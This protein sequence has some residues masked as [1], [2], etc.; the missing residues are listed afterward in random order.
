MANWIFSFSNVSRSLQ[1]CVQHVYE[2]YTTNL[3]FRAFSI[4]LPHH[5]PILNQ[6]SVARIEFFFFSCVQFG[7][8]AR[9]DSASESL[10]L[11]FFF[12]SNPNKSLTEIFSLSLVFKRKWN[13]CQVSRSDQNVLLFQTQKCPTLRL[14]QSYVEW[15]AI[16]TKPNNPTWLSK[17]NS[18]AAAARHSVS[19]GKN[20]RIFH[21]LIMLLEP[22]LALSICRLEL[23]FKM[24]RSTA[25]QHGALQQLK[26]ALKITLNCLDSQKL[27]MD[28]FH[29]YRSCARGN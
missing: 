15:F 4:H 23:K 12:T 24:Y 27:C 3:F 29:K 28:T 20:S 25:R 16:S 17:S 9:S 13:L 6:F 5:V 19:E 1:S 8:G 14:R 18:A 2:L 22:Y 10:W 7:V 21:Y 11:D 26:R